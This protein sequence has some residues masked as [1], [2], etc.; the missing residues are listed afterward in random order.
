MAITRIPKAGLD[1]ALQNEFNGK[2]DKAGGTMTGSI[3]MTNGALF[4]SSVTSDDARNTGYKMADGQDIGEMNRSSQYY[5]D[6][7]TN[8]NGYLPNGN[9]ASNG[10]WNPPNGNWWTWGVSGVPTGNCANWG[11]YDGAGGTSQVFNAVSV[12]FN[13]DGYYE[14]ANEIGGS[15]YHRWYRNCNCGSFNC[16]T[17]CNCNCACCGCC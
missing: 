10:Y 16:R 3:T 13:Y 5:D 17:N 6:R 12:G 14:A 9:C 8:C 15:E 4:K 1:D 7:A 2:L 11:S